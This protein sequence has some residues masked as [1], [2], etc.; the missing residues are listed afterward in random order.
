[1]PDPGP[2]GAPNITGFGFSDIGFIDTWTPVWRHERSYTYS[3]NFTKVHG[4]HEIRC[5]AETFAAS[6]SITG[7]LKPRI[8]AA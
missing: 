7:S 2:G 4:A 8:P 5:G 6:T 3:S 1:M